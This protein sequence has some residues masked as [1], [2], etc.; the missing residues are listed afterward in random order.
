MSTGFEALSNGAG[1]VDLS[2]HGRL[3]ATGDDRARLLH[4]M[5]TNHIQGM[6]PGDGAYA[7]FLNAQGRIQADATIL[8]FENHFLIDTEPETRETLFAHLDKFIIADDVTLEDVT[9]DTFSLGVEGPGAAEAVRS[10]GFEEP[11]AQMAHVSR[12]GITVERVSS[13]GAEGF[14]IYG[15]GGKKAYTLAALEAAGAMLASADEA[16]ARR[17]A[18]FKPRYGQDIDD[19]SLPQETQLMS[20]MHFSKGCYLGQE[21][22][23]RVRSRGHVNR[24]LMG[25]KVEGDAVPARGA[26]L[27]AGGK[28]AGEV[29]SATKFP[30]GRVR[31]LAWVRVPYDKGGGTVG[32]DGRPAELFPPLGAG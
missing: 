28:E 3:R 20:A 14:R 26:M 6:K 10:A 8:C 21:I 30:G 22:V 1:I 5:T 9:D 23:E 13:T 4:A 15:T 29:T 24:H 25:F 17:I 18:N 16:T 27:F 32:I 12:E 11:T 19:A 31:G 7:F 2:A